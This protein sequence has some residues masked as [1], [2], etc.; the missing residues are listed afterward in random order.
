MRQTP[1]WRARF[2]AP[3]SGG[4]APTGPMLAKRTA[5]GD[6]SPGSGR[7]QCSAIA[8]MTGERC[9]KDAIGGT[10]RCKSHGGVV[11]ALRKLRQERGAKAQRRDP[12]HHARQSLFAVSLE[13]P[14]GFVSDAIGIERGKQIEEFKNLNDCIGLSKK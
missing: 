3:G 2:T 7:R 8:K 5:F 11:Y 9:R 13:E 6:F 4:A 12:D 1:H 10:T 14:E